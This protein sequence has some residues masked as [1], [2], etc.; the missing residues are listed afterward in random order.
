[1][2]KLYAQYAAI[3]GNSLKNGQRK[4][5]LMKGFNERF[6]N[7]VSGFEGHLLS[8]SEDLALF[9]SLKPIG[10]VS[11]VN[12]HYDQ[13]PGAHP[14][15]LHIKT[16]NTTEN[17]YITSLFIDI[18]GSTALFRRYTP[19]TVANITS[20]IQK[21]ALHTCWHFG[22]YIQRFHGDGLLVY[23]GNRNI[24]ISQS[25]KH[26]LDAASFFSV[27]IKN[28]L[29][30]MFYEHGIENINTRIGIDTGDAEDVL[31]H[32]AGMGECSE[33]TTCSLHTSLAAHMQGNAPA[34]GI[35]VGDNVKRLALLS[36]D[37]YSIQ[38]DSQGK[39]DRYIYQIPEEN[40]NYTQWVF[41]WERYLK[42]NSSYIVGNDGSIY[43][44][45]TAPA[46]VTAPPKNMD[47]LKAQVQGYKPY[48]RD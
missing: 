24:T 36:P 32:L 37:L 38:K 47:Y 25:V 23:F 11:G 34:N 48:Y 9:E 40:F 14:N 22:G 16:Q 10:G 46:I 27:F 17:H 30:N 1:M 2:E 45:G 12:A 4:G 43:I 26:A 44:P 21:A 41:N 5:Q 18:K 3:V 28:D 42:T 13:K 15:F 33:I 6:S 8:K 19:F 39:E 20:T 31:W 35:M 7:G 29:K